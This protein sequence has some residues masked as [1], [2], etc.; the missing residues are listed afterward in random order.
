[1]AS[2]ENAEL[3]ALVARLR[4]S[5]IDNIVAGWE[6]AARDDREAADAITEL[7]QELAEKS[8]QWQSTMIYLGDE[9]D[10]ARAENEALRALLKF[11]RAAIE[12]VVSAE[13][14]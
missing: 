9:R 2:L 14:E 1:M 6:G 12:D 7:R 5:N 13:S 4:K 8:M 10:A 3:D 11:I